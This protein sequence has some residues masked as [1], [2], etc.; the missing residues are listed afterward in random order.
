[1]SPER[2]GPTRLVHAP[3]PLRFR[4]EREQFELGLVPARARIATAGHGQPRGSK[5]ILRGSS[6][7]AQPLRT[8]KRAGDI[9]NA[10]LAQRM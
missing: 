2:N 7:E 6:E 4:F 3:D 8:W 5:Q 9:G 10:W 1:M